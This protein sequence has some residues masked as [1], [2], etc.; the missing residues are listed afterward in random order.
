MLRETTS[1]DE[2]YRRLIAYVLGVKYPDELYCV[3]EVDPLAISYILQHRASHVLA[4]ANDNKVREIEQLTEKEGWLK[5]FIEFGDQSRWFI[6]PL[7]CYEEKVINVSQNYASMRIFYSINYFRS[8]Q[9]TLTVMKR[10]SP[11]AINIKSM[12]IL[13][14]ELEEYM[15]KASLLCPSYHLQ[16]NCLL[17]EAIC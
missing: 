1:K 13:T 17:V 9:L 16:V 15:I 6:G 4:D 5:P 3:N 2:A 7:Y 11:R 8:H 14:K 12:T 10:F